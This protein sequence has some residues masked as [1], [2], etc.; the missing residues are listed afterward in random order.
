MKIF[1]LD[2]HISVI[3]DLKQIFE[4]MGHEVTSWSISGHNWVFGRDPKKTDV[5]GPNNWR[6][7]NKSICDMFYERYKDELSGYDAFL[8]TYPPAFSMLYERFQKP[9]ILHIP[10]RYETPFESNPQRWEEFNEYLRSGIDSGMIIPVANSEYD[11]RYFEF[12]VKRECMLIPSVCKYTEME[13]NPKRDRFLYYSRLRLNLPPNI[14][15]KND[16][17]RYEWS[18]I[19]EY[20]GII[21]I[22][23]NCSTMSIFEYYTA[24]IPLFCPSEKFMMSLYASHGSEVLSEITWNRTFG[25]LPGSSIDCDRSK[26]PNRYD[27]IEIMS[28]WISHSDFYNREWM[29][30]ITYFDSFEELHAILENADLAD[31]SNKMKSFNSERQK[32]IYQMWG[33]TLKKIS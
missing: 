2:C 23:Y 20:S 21:M 8:C 13:W 33:E 16:L 12:F 19:A 31:I 27:D 24:N 30:Y 22:P 15:D 5:I 17:G 29:P 3:A 32:R 6:G 1:N 9:V 11:K 25:N 10:I 7:M 4:E 14:V 28:K 26:D 18:D